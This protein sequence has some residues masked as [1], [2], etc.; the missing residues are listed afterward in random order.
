MTE[1]KLQIGNRV[2]IYNV[3]LD[4][5]IVTVSSINE[6]DGTFGYEFSEEDCKAKGLAPKIFAGSYWGYIDEAHIIS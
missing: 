5:N 2:R 6:E 3:S 4:E 1:N